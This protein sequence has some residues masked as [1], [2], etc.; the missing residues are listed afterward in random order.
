MI[1]PFKYQFKQPILDGVKIHSIRA[2]KHSRWKKGRIIHMAT[3][4]RTKKYNCFAEKKCTGTQQIKID[5]SAYYMNDYFVEVDGRKLTLA[6]TQK[7]AWNDGFD[8]LIYFYQWF[9]ENYEGKIIH[10]TD[11]RY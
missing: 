9:N 1:L 2:D 10:W 8:N 11:Y 5:T 4:V 6:E 7:L 3:G